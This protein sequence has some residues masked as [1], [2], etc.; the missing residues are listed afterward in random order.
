MWKLQLHRNWSKLST[1]GKLFDRNAIKSNLAL[2]LNSQWNFRRN[3][4]IRVDSDL[5]VIRQ[6]QAI[7]DKNR[8]EEN[9]WKRPPAERQ[10]K[11]QQRQ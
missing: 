4:T 1:N 11:S 8:K 10:P 5:S 7:F 3:D 2:A 9:E 6:W